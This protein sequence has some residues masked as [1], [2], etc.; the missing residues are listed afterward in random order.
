VGR[1]A[2]AIANFFGLAFWPL[3]TAITVVLL[4]QPV[5]VLSLAS[6]T[7]SERSFQHIDAAF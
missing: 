6:L 5:Y 1:P 4:L 2:G 7:S 3:A